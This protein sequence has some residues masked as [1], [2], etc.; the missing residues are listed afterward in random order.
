MCEIVQDEDAEVG[1][2][3]KAQR[4]VGHGKDLDFTLRETGSH[5]GV[6]SRTV[7]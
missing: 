5:S 4:L 2:G 3:Q 7:I 6:L 1:R